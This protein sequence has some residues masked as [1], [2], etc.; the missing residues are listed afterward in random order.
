MPR[1]GIGKT[2]RW[3][4]TV[5]LAMIPLS[6]WAQN[7]NAP[8]QGFGGTWWQ[9]YAK[10]CT[11]CGGTPDANTIS[12]K[13]GSNWGHPGGAPRGN[14]PAPVMNNNVGVQQQAARRQR[15]E[16]EQQREEEERQRQEAEAARLRQ[17]EFDRSKTEALGHMKDIARTQ[18]GL[19]DADT[20]D[21]FALKNVDSVGPS[22]MELKD[23]K[24]APN[25]NPAAPA[26]EWG[27]INTAVVD[28][29]CLGLDPNQ[30]IAVD[31]HVVR[32]QQRVFPA[33]VDP[34][35]F[36]NPNFIKGMEAEMR[37]G[38][39]AY[40]EAA[41]CF[42]LALQ[43]RPDD[44]V[45]RNALLL[46]EDI[47]KERLVKEQNDQSRAAMLSLQ[48]YAALM[49][50]EDKTAKAYIAEARK[51]DPDDNNIKFMESL[52]SLDL[53]PGGTYPERKAAYKI[54]AS[55]LVSVTN[56]NYGAAVGMLEAAQHL[57][58]ADPFI[59]SLLQAIRKY[60]AA[61]KTA[62]KP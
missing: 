6:A 19:K 40:A 46:A 59:G 47:H 16:E 11:E 17:E 32:G 34:A 36:E 61:S 50:G 20:G 41:R 1:I 10:W 44:P 56:Q 55:S 3:A 5:L 18:F 45:V 37:P 7:C 12:C 43:D 57:Q 42:K 26:C 48:T 13:K 53:G 4:F 60:D 29:R 54:V 33:Q 38:A 62:L 49:A 8:P 39:A 28:L 22:T 25:D 15:E 14:A 35:T 24:D 27:T 31:P 58:P 30:P 52:A 21:N 2:A 9:S 23:L 51:L